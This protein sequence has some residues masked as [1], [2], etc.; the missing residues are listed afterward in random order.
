MS[1]SR[2]GIWTSCA[3]AYERLGFTLTPRARHSGRRTP[4]GPIEPF[5]TAN[6]CI[7]LRQG[8]IEL[9][10]VV[11]PRRIQRHDRR[12]P[13]PLRRAPYHRARGGRRGGSLE[14]LRRPAWTFPVSPISSARWTT[15]IP[16]G[17][18]A[19][20]ARVP[21]PDSPE[22]RI[23][24]IRHL[25][26]EAI[27][28]ERF[29]SHPNGAVALEEVVLAVAAPA[30]SAAR[31]SLLAG[32]PVTPD[33]A[34]G[35]ALAMPQGRVRV[36]PPDALTT[37]FPGAA[38]PSLPFIAGFSVR[39]GDGNAAVARLLGERGIPHRA[40]PDGVLVDSAVAGGANLRFRSGSLNGAPIQAARARRA[41]CS[42]VAVEG[43]PHAKVGFG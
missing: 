3:T 24:L 8:Y 10:A 29:V 22:G 31:L 43:E 20:F 11:D 13:R 17:P 1:A 23:Q 7:M 16:A 30:E 32:R 18:K 35:Y 36:L 9:L 2:A 15:R 33:P 40:A 37:V 27:W 38:I 6:R 39:T 19:R 28:Q 34:G 25:T 4:D 14:R 21:L 41:I 5:G 12:A 26:P 42:L